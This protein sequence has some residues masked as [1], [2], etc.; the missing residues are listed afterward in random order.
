ML[1]VDRIWSQPSRRFLCSVPRVL[2][3]HSAI[4]MHVHTCIVRKSNSKQFQIN[5]HNC[6]FSFLGLKSD[7]LAN[8]LRSYRRNGIR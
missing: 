6:K 3:E 7:K 8:D 5:Y 1:S 4:Y 2:L